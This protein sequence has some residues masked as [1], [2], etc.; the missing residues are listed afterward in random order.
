MSRFD[1]PRVNPDH[2]LP[3]HLSATLED[4]LQQLVDDICRHDGELAEILFGLSFPRGSR[5]E[6]RER[7]EAWGRA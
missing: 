5:A 7:I 1:L 6:R 4:D 3:P 2:A